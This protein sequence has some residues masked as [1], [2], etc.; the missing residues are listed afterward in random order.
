MQT[1]Q[2][3]ALREHRAAQMVDDEGPSGHA[4]IQGHRSAENDAARLRGIPA[5]GRNVAGEIPHTRPDR[6]VL[7]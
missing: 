7:R 6:V 2:R 3:Q 4:Q 5:I 1:L